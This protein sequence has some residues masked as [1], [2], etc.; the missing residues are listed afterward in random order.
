MR[1]GDLLNEESRTRYRSPNAA[2]VEA[3]LAQLE[4]AEAALLIG[5]GMG[6]VSLA[7]LGVMEHGMHI[8]AQTCH[9]GGTLTLLRD[10]LPRFGATVTQVDQ[11]STAPFASMMSPNTKVVLLE[12]PTSSLPQR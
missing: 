8:V 3:V 6:A 5:S 10:I 9:Y 4:G 1:P 12:S 7:V 2:Q 11:R